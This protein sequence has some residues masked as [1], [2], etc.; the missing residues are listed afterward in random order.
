MEGYSCPVD[1][2]G[3]FATTVSYCLVFSLLSGLDNSS[4]KHVAISPFH[5][6]HESSADNGP[7][8]ASWKVPT[9]T[10]VTRGRWTTVC[11]SL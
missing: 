11:H 7:Y 9:C 2:Y 3:I 8:T 5:D 10:Q 6:K 1:E 4:G